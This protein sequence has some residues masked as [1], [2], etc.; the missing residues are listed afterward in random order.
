MNFPCLFFKTF[1]L[2]S[3]CCREENNSEFENGQAGRPDPEPDL[4]DVS[5]A[6]SGHLPPPDGSAGRGA[7]C[8]PRANISL[9]DTRYPSPAYASDSENGDT[10]SEGC[11]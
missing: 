10:R 5:K 2:L 9:Q 4:D 6:F 3:C 8:P 1:R 7:G 11:C